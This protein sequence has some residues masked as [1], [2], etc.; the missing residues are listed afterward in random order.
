MRD[1][2]HGQQL[3]PGLLWFLQVVFSNLRLTDVSVNMGTELLPPGASELGSLAHRAGLE[4]IQWSFG[5]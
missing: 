2:E 1:T 5:N 4:S 3:A